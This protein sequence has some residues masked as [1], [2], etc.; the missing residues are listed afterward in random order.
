MRPRGSP[1][2]AEPCRTHWCIEGMFG[3]LES[4]LHSEMASL[5]P[6]AAL[7]GFAVS[8][9]ASN[10]PGLL[11]AVPPEVWPPWHSA[12]PE[13]LAERLLSLARHID[14][15]QVA[16]SKRKPKQPEG[17]V[18]GDTARSHVATARVLARARTRP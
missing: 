7:L 8:V 6:R 3:R 11:I 17:R 9:L 12:T 13:C 4:V 10:V 5:A 15:R 2:I 18:N 1:E 14:P 16:I